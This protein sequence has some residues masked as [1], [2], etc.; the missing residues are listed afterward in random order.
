MFLLVLS[1]LYKIRENQEPYRIFV[2]FKEN[3]NFK[4]ISASLL[5]TTTNFVSRLGLGLGISVNL[6]K[7][8]F[9]SESGSK[10][11]PN[12]YAE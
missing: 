9:L 5:T 7:G 1:G 3:L 4:A 6:S 8:S 2:A 11:I 10:N 12:H